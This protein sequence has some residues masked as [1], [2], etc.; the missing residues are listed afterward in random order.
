MSLERAVFRA[1]ARVD[2]AVQEMVYAISHHRFEQ[3]RRLA[4]EE[5]TERENLRRLCEDYGI[6]AI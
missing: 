4:I 1:R 3:A 6:D 2:C 5:R